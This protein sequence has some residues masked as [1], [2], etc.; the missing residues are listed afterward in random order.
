MNSHL[1]QTI[2]KNHDDKIP[3]E[4]NFTY[5]DYLNISACHITEK[6]ESLVVNIYNPIGRAVATNVRVPVN[7]KEYIVFDAQ[8]NV[9]PS[10]MSK[11]FFCFYNKDMYF[12]SAINF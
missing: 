10:Q 3:I 4:L 6:E 12:I 8:G 9:V 1:K 7:F 11:V 5:C 2:S